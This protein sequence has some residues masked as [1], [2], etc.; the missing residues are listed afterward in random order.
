[1]R[2]WKI[3]TPWL[4]GLL[5]GAVA[6]GPGLFSLA[7]FSWKEHEMARQ[8]RALTRQHDELAQEHERLTADP[9]YVEGLARSTF[10][11]AKPGELVIPIAS[12]ARKR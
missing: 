12:E 1:M 6:C 8:V 2:V 9:V 5:L 4:V 3:R 10:K 11:L 7:W